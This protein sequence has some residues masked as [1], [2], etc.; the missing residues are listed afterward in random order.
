M[1]M[2]LHNMPTQREQPP[3]QKP[4]ERDCLREMPWKLRK[5]TMLRL[6]VRLLPMLPQQTTRPLRTTPEQLQKPKLPVHAWRKPMRTPQRAPGKL[7]PVRMRSFALMPWKPP[8]LPNLMLVMRDPASN[9]LP[10]L[11]R[12]LTMRPD[13]QTGLAHR[14]RL[15]LSVPDN[16]MIMHSRLRT[17]SKTRH[18]SVLRPFLLPMLPR[19][20]LI[21]TPLR[22]EPATTTQPNEG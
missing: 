15:K 8:D 18:P 19:D 1:L 12:L 13:N 9:T 22:L 4:T 7:K 21:W 10:P 3:S 6:T 11:L 5:H 20:M 16:P 17:T 2:P 14:R